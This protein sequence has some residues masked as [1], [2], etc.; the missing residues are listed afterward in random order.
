VPVYLDGRG[1]YDLIL[2]TGAIFTTIEPSLAAELDLEL[3]GSIPVVSVAGTHRGSRGRLDRVELGPFS[4]S[5][6]DVV[7]SEMDF[8]RS[9]DREIRG[10]LGQ[11]AL[12]HLSFGIDHRRRRILFEKP[13]KSDEA[14]PLVYCEGRPAVSFRPVRS[15]AKLTVVLDS[16][17][18]F[19]MLFEKPGIAL[20]TRSRSRG[21]FE[22]QTVSGEARLPIVQLEGR[23]GGLRIP[24]TATA[25]Q[26]DRAAGGREEDGL[27]PT[28]LFRMVYFDRAE[29]QL[30]LRR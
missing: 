12:R 25:V 27:L 21:N 11:S 16:G 7:W 30:L 22:T 28:Q 24:G 14:L 6:V 5:G 3:L 15:E 8:L 29:E 1:P 19:P 17:A 2:D 26:D 10:V 18:A 4:V 13:E 23:V 20:P 9:V